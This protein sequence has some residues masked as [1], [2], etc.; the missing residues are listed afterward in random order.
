MTQVVALL[1]VL[2]RSRKVFIIL[3]RHVLH[4][5]DSGLD[6]DRDRVFSYEAFFPLAKSEYVLTL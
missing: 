1:E 3:H 4:G 6:Q 5:L 2:V